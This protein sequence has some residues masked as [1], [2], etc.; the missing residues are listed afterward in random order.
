MGSSF[1][2]LVSS[3]TNFGLFVYLPE[4]MLDGLIHITELG[5]DYFIFDERQQ[6]LVG[7]KTGMRF[8]NG[9]QIRVLI[10][11]VNLSR[12]YIDLALAEEDNTK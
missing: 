5:D 2:G 11:A 4:L 7:K 3:I 9:Q 8:A 12:L 6:M 1:T 10:A